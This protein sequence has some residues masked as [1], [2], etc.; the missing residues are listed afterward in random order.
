MALYIVHDMLSH[1]ASYILCPLYLYL[2]FVRSNS[3]LLFR[4]LFPPSLP[5]SPCTQDSVWPNLLT[6]QEC[7]L[8][9]ILFRNGKIEAKNN[10]VCR[11][12]RERERERERLF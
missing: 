7:R 1:S 6:F 8:S 2:S 3:V 4:Q 5:P 12:E 11:R 9:E 10:S